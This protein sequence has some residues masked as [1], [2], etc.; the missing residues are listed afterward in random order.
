MFDHVLK[1]NMF[2]TCLN[3]SG[4][5]THT[6]QSNNLYSVQDCFFS[7]SAFP[8]GHLQKYLWFLLS[9]SHKWC[10]K[11]Q[12][13]W[14]AHEMS[15]YLIKLDGKYKF[16]VYSVLVELFLR[17]MSKRYR[18]I[19]NLFLKSETCCTHANWTLSNMFHTYLSSSRFAHVETGIPLN[20][21]PQTHLNMFQTCFYRHAHTGLNMFVKR[22]F[23]HVLSRSGRQFNKCGQIC[24]NVLQ[25]CSFH[26]QTC[27]LNISPH[28]WNT[29]RHV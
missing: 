20:C 6:D 23:K 18:E 16:S 27:L 22:C 29:C 19:W 7:K 4:H 1:I 15:K 5:M 9:K 25:T 24:F 28:V 11:L 21:R 8:V 26:G 13:M 17:S 2:G 14:R 12:H 3:M 10:Q